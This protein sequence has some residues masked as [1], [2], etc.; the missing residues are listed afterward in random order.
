M[1]NWFCAGQ[2]TVFFTDLK[3]DDVWSVL[4][5]SPSTNKAFD[6]RFV[7]RP[8]TK[9]RE[10]CSNRKLNSGRRL[11]PCELGY[12]VRLQTITWGVSGQ[13]QD[14]F[15]EVSW[16]NGQLKQITTVLQMACRFENRKKKTTTH[17]YH[18]N[19]FSFSLLRRSRCILSL[20][21][22][23]FS[24]HLVVCAPGVA[25]R[26]AINKNKTAVS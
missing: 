22:K 19:Q 17:F 20:A 18:P 26:S 3:H 6:I 7:C 11:L 1:N 9:H 23:A 15:N 12:N 10:G 4:V 5:L 13:P 24:L 21:T 14:K 2:H 8:P 25:K 16:L